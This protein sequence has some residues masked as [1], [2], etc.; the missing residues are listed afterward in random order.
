ML[1]SL[2]GAYLRPRPAR[3]AGGYEGLQVVVVIV[4]VDVDVDVVIVIR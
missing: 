2:I 3:N 4:D 1:L